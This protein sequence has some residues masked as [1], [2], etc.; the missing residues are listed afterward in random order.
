MKVYMTSAMCVQCSYPT[1]VG[2]CLM[3]QQECN[4]S[5][6]EPGMISACFVRRLVVV[7]RAT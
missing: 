6:Q 5:Q 2:M 1:G 7:C 4:I 3:Y